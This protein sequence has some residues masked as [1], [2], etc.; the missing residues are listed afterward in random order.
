MYFSI[1]GTIAL[2][3][4]INFSKI[5]EILQ[6]NYEIKLL[7]LTI[8]LTGTLYI[9]RF[10]IKLI[11][12]FVNIGIITDIRIIDHDKTIFFRDTMDSIDMSQIQNIEQVKEGIIPSLFRYGDIKVFMT[13]SAATKT[14][15]FVPNAK[16]H[17]RCMN[18]QKET[19]QL[20]LRAHTGLETVMK[21]EAESVHPFKPPLENAVQRTKPWRRKNHSE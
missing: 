19:R 7:F 20:Q 17:F 9:H 5:I 4:M 12:Y 13:A 16:F 18:R 10:F 3:G 6:G 15:H 2:L 11:N 1:F 14:F 21:V 8:F